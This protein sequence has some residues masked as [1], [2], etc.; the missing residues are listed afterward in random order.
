ML[1]TIIF[2]TTYH[3]VT[4]AMAGRGDK[5]NGKQG[6]RSVTRQQMPKQSSVLEGQ[7]TL[8]MENGPRPLSGMHKQQQQQRKQIINHG[9]GQRLSLPAVEPTV[10]MKG[11]ST[12]NANRIRQNQNLLRANQGRQ[13]VATVARTAGPCQHNANGNKAQREHQ[14]QLDDEGYNNDNQEEQEFMDSDDGKE[15]SNEE[16]GVDGLCNQPHHDSNHKNE[17]TNHRTP[18]SS[19]G[20]AARIFDLEHLLQLSHPGMRIFCRNFKIINVSTNVIITVATIMNPN[21]TV[22]PGGVPSFC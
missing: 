14:D 8:R 4:A 7:T 20:A 9:K 19:N 13:N 1:P 21:A 16:N 17:E 11:K 10:T 22:K 18:S 12:S 5:N 15:N 6:T 3:R 2:L